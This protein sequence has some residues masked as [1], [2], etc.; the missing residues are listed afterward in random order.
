MKEQFNKVLNDIS[1]IV[2][3]NKSFNHKLKNG[4]FNIYWGIK[5]NNMLDFK[6]ICILNKIIEL[7]KLGNTITILIADIHTILN[8]RNI[9]IESETKKFINNLWNLIDS[10]TLTD[11]ERGKI[12]IIKGSDFQLDANYILDMY[13]LI[14]IHGSIKDYCNEFDLD[15]NNISFNTILD[16]ILQTLDEEHIKKIIG[17]DI[18]CQIGYSYN[19]K[20]HTFSKKSMIKLGYKAKTYILYDIPKTLIT[21][22]I[23]INS[24]NFIS[25]VYTL[26]TVTL[27]FIINS[28]LD[29]A[30]FKKIW[31]DNEIEKDRKLLD[32]MSKDNKCQ[33]IIKLKRN[34]F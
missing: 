4:L 9:P 1:N 12:N 22:P 5:V 18:D 7:I 28:L 20:Q 15:I 25:M 3:R 16:P 6:I 33:I 23:Y 17:K 27:D 14:S 2:G 29:N 10:Y 26:N 32:S 8:N 24:N 30:K 19:I 13:K 11:E 34:L 31:A 21:N